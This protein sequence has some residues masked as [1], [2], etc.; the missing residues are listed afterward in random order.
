MQCFVLKSYWTHLSHLGRS[1][2]QGLGRVRG[3][4]M[5]S[6]SFLPLSHAYSIYRL[7]HASQGPA[8]ML[9]FLST[10][11]ECTSVR[12]KLTVCVCVCVCC[13]S[14]TN[15]VGTHQLPASRHDAQRGYTPAFL[16]LPQTVKSTLILSQL[17]KASGASR[18]SVYPVSTM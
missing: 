8:A 9:I 3:R 11:Q 10:G 14:S 6:L 1:H 5:Y 7:R 13:T 16:Y 2:G 17:K 4:V 18:R 12:C 15:A